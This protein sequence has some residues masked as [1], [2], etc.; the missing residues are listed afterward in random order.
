MKKVAE[1]VTS[2]LK[3]VVNTPERVKAFGRT[4]EIARFKLGQLAQAAEYAGY[5]GVL[6]VQ[7]MK[8]SKTPT[9]EEIVSF[10]AQ[11]VGIASPAVIPLLS[12]A[13][14]E[15]IEWLEEQD[16][17]MGALELFAKVVEKNRDFFTS[18]NAERIRS[19]FASLLPAIP[20]AG[21]DTLMT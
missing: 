8:L 11:G 19:V 16:D 14:K 2:E 5:I 20:E 1:K 3:E 18:A 10:A 12:I 13:T 4:Y 21:T 7:A 17:A 9:T 6:V 15:P